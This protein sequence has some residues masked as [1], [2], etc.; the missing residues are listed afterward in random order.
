[1]SEIICL[2]TQI[3]I[4]GVKKEA[5][6]GQ[7]EM[8][9]K[10]ELFLKTCENDKVEI[11]IPTIVIGEILSG[12]ADE[13][14]SE[15]IKYMTSQFMIVPFDI[16]SAVVFAKLWKIWKENKRLR[17]ELKDQG[18]KREEMKADCM[19]VAIAK[20]RNAD[21]IYSHDDKLRTFA[22]G[23]IKTKSLSEINLPHMQDNLF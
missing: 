5:S 23:H 10:A 19:I 12:M 18:A 14:Q 4:W 1:M 7:E 17:K 3:V 6:P 13:K 16:R 11:I 21:C 8:L 2:D 9:A 15:F 22:E 20:S